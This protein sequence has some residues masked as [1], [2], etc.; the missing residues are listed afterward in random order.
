[1]SAADLYA[2]IFLPA[3]ANKEVLTVKGEK[4]YS[5]NSGADKDNDGKIT[6][7]D[8]WTRLK[9]HYVDDASFD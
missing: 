9:T 7:A 3:F 6:K 8:L 5:W 1:M 2:I 4:Y